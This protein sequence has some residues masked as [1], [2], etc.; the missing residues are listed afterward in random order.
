MEF[1]ISKSPVDGQEMPEPLVAV[2]DHWNA[3]RGASIFPPWD[4]FRLESLPAH[5]I[6]WCVVADVVTGNDGEIDFVYRFWGTA[7]AEFQGLEMTG[8]S[9]SEIKPAKVADKVRD[10]FLAILETPEP[11]FF[12]TQFTFPDG[13][14]ISWESLR[15][16]LGPDEKTVQKIIG[17]GAPRSF[18]PAYFRAMDGDPHIDYFLRRSTEP[19]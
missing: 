1:Q 5:V 3:I 17:V 19:K 18:S 13:D 6:P 9:V 2:L 14:E 7:R 8:K 10:E 15:L 12:V 4:T 16:P 11:L